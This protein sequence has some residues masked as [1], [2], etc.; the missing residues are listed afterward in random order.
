[1]SYHTVRLIALA[2][3]LANLCL[4]PIWWHLLGAAI[5]RRFA[6]LTLPNAAA[7]AIIFAIL[8]LLFGAILH[9]AGRSPGSRTE[10]LAHWLPVAVVVMVTNFLRQE[11]IP[12]LHA[13][14]LVP[15]YGHG[16]VV[17]ASAVL[18]VAV[19]WLL[20]RT[21][22]LAYRIAEFIVIIL[23]PLVALTVGSLAWG[24]ARHVTERD[25]LV[26]H[27]AATRVGNRAKPRV[28][29][30]IFDELDQRTTFEARPNGLAVPAFERLIG[31]ALSATQ[32]VPP[33]SMYTFVSV[34]SLLTGR[35]A[36][37][38]AMT[39]PN[40]VMLTVSDAPA[41][42]PLSTQPNVLARARAG[43]V[44]TAVVGWQLP[45]CR[46][47]RDSI[48]ECMWTRTGFHLAA[49]D[50]PL[51]AMIAQHIGLIMRPIPLAPRLLPLW[52][53]HRSVIRGSHIAAYER[54]RA[55]ALRVATDP[56][57]GLGFVHWPV[58]HIPAIY[59]SATREF[60]TGA[61]G[62]YIDNIELADRSLA[63]VRVAMER[64]GTWEATNVLVSADHSWRSPP[65]GSAAVDARV[66]F[67]LKL[68]GRREALRYD[69][70]FNTVITH[71][72]LLALLAREIRRVDDVR[73]WLD[74]R[75]RATNR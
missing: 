9:G 42:V 74:A 21:R 13:L 7:A 26:D 40:E 43:G 60:T 55:A 19:V 73:R 37:A 41:P 32:A 23:A 54:V 63:E 48:T 70:P 47:F 30:M 52:E 61:E 5:D 6:P 35:L 51:G 67:I 49:L 45:Y 12:Q 2:A 39:A 28:L 8:T 22:R 57:I 10:Q 16:A 36:T 58:P 1:M 27:T 4:L 24:A 20:I 69:R 25:R 68:A 44:D 11:A 62:S 33:S 59:N 3:S 38:F 50:L 34:P 31:E 72:L 75:R 18:T 14:E 46:I 17:A 66:P 15:R 64:A 29:W 53:F 56:H 71:D 65:G